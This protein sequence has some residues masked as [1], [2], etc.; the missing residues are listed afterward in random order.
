MSTNGGSFSNLCSNCNSFN[1]TRL[2]SLRKVYNVTFQATD[3]A[4]NV[5]YA[6]V[7]FTRI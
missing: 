4:G 5:G 1:A 6:S 3:Y 2:F 7:V